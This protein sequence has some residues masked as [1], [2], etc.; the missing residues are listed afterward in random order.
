[1]I[2]SFRLQGQNK[3]KKHAADRESP[4]VNFRD[5]RSTFNVTPWSDRM[6]NRHTI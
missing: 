2:C 6:W 4:D 3:I 5:L 1:M